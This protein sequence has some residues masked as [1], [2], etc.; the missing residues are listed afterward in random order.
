ME[1]MVCSSPKHSNNALNPLPCQNMHSDF[2]FNFE[3]ENILSSSLNE[4][5]P[6]IINNDL[7]SGK[8]KNVDSAKI[9]ETS[10]P[11]DTNVEIV[12]IDMNKR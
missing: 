2:G 3:S 9:D 7:N 12:K 11:H 1:N 10:A 8:T 6:N 5:W 4:S